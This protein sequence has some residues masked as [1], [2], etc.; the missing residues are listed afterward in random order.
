L[1]RVALVDIYK[2]YYDSHF[3]NALVLV[4][5]ICFY[6]MVSNESTSSFF[7]RMASI[8]LVIISWITAPM[9]F[10]P[11]ATSDTLSNDVKNLHDWVATDFTHRMLKDP[12]LHIANEEPSESKRKD[13]LNR[14][15]TS[16]STW[17]AWFLKSIVDEWEEED[18]WFSHVF[19]SRVKQFIQ[20]FI[21]LLWQYFPWFV[22]GQF[23]WRLQ[24]LYYLLILISCII[25]V[26]AIDARYT[27][28]NEHFTIWKGLLFLCIPPLLVF[29]FYGHVNFSF[30]V[31]S[32]MLHTIVAFILSDLVLGIYNVWVKH[33][34][35]K[36]SW[37]GEMD[38]TRELL[39]PRL[40][41]PRFLIGL[42]RMWPYVTMILLSLVGLFTVMVSG[43]LTTLLFN[44]RVADMWHRAYLL[45][46]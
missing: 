26:T 40:L 27:N 7:L 1:D 18:R 30:L 14:W 28:E 5:A 34:S 6:G 38:E 8:I 16:K 46:K 17:Q 4:A 41:A 42:Q 39:I 45:R 13:L 31:V 29:F 12:A 35:K 15:I 44:G 25:F 11:Y 23:Y 19:L 21:N 24:S 20:K 22:F 2:F 37:E 9:I 36:T 10:N 32:T 33:S 43:G 3:H